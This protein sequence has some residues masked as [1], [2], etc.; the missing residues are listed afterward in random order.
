MRI[1]VYQQRVQIPG[2][3]G[4]PLERPDTSGTGRAIS[5][6]G[7]SLVGIGLDIGEDVVRQKRQ[8][9]DNKITNL[10][11]QFDSKL[12]ADYI[13]YHNQQA[14]AAYGSQERL[15]VFQDKEL[16]ESTKDIDNPYIKQKVA[17][18]IQQRINNRRI[19]YAAH[20]SQ[21]RQIVSQLTRD[22]GL[23]AASQSAFSGVGGLEENLNTV[24][25]IIKT[26]HENGEISTETS[27]AWLLNAERKIA[28]RTLAGVVNR[29]PE[30]SI[31]LMKS[32]V[33]NKYLDSKIIEHYTNEARQE[34]TRQEKI[35]E[36]AIK[37]QQKTLEDNANKELSDSL[38][39]GTLNTELL[40]KHRNSLS[41]EQY[42]SW[43]KEYDSQITNLSKQINEEKTKTV[44]AELFVKAITGDELSTSQGR[45][46]YKQEIARMVASKEIEPA[47][48]RQLLNDVN[49]I[50]KGNPERKEA[51]KQSIKSIDTAYKNGI[52]GE[53][54]ESTIE[55]ERMVRDLRAWSIQNPDKNPD[56][57]VEK[58]LTAKRESWVKSLFRILPGVSLFTSPPAESLT[59]QEMRQKIM[60]ESQ[61]KITL[62][63]KEELSVLIQGAGLKTQT[64]AIEFIKNKYGI[65]Q[66][67]A[68]NYYRSLK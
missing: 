48:A 39:S 17:Q 16:K 21:Q 4:I 37:N 30:S 61:R 35:K 29:Q 13:D 20:E 36:A 54:I 58:V 9:E 31:E 24:R 64:Q 23:D 28:E 55:R 32:G 15:D 62:P 18:H 38:L 53:G 22:K 56:E 57:F 26:Q 45:E 7:Q 27:E 14:D 43:V 42:K 40:G 34:A 68:V 67:E 51:I 3:S 25:E 11:I 8:D 33:F 65:S 1:P 47:K 5:G 44:E 59:S 60:G 6:I 10:A 49:D 50:D 2:S 41:P 66:K 63:T 46:A 12:T 19:D 52:L